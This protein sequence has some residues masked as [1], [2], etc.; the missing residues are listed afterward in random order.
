MTKLEVT[1]FIIESRGVPAAFNGFKVAHVSDLHNYPHGAGLAA[2]INAGA[3]DIIVI[4]GD[5]IDRHNIKSGIAQGFVSAA[6]SIAP[7]YFTPG[8]HEASCS[9]YPALREF[10][11][12]AG[13]FVLENAAAEIRRGN[14]TVVIGGL[15]DPWFRGEK[16]RGPRG[17][18]EL[19]RDIEGIFKGRD[20]FK[21]LISHRPELFKLYA[22]GG[23]DIT[24]SGHAHGGL[25]RLPLIGGVF[26]PHQGFFPKYTAG[27]YR[28]GGSQMLV[29]RGLGDSAAPFRINNPPQLVFAVLKLKESG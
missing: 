13:V 19:A 1:D 2:A 27:L 29:S 7:V 9:A 24:F 14:D 20:G 25:V 3:P 28:S 12:K 17:G 8:N 18:E 5:L 16:G 6:V 15:C 11:L 23:A 26:A 22:A 21:M 4:S 10:L